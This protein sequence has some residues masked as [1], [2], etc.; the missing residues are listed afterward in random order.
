MHWP[1]IVE[2]TVWHLESDKNFSII[3]KEKGNIDD[4]DFQRKGPWAMEIVDMTFM[5]D[6]EIDEAG[7]YM[8]PVPNPL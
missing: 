5:R 1:L 4:W 3:S 7:L 6:K 8:L 2:D